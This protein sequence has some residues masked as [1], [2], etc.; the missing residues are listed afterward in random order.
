MNSI[1]IWAEDIGKCG[2]RF[3]IVPEE[4]WTIRNQI[5]NCGGD[6]TCIYHNWKKWCDGL[7]FFG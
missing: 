3:L 5:I 1:G 7:S 2:T 4:Q 6:I